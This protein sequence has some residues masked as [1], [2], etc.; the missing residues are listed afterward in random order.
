MSECAKLPGAVLLLSLAR[1]CAAQS[2]L[3]HV[4]PDPPQTQ[5]HDM[6]YSDMADM[7][8]MDDRAPFGLFSLDQLEWL[9]DERFA[10]QIDAWYGGDIDKLWL[11]AEAA[12]DSGETHDA[13]AELLW[14][15]VIGRWWNLQTGLRQDLGAH[16]RTWV[17]FGIQGL[18]PGFVHV[19]AT[20]YLGEGG[21]TA[22]RFVA[23]YDLLLTQ[24]WV[25]QPELELELL[26][27][28]DAMRGISAGLSDLG[29]GLRLRYEFRREFAPYA[30]I[31]WAARA[32]GEDADEL[33]LL[34]GL[35]L[36]F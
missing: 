13:S 29:L 4:P 32:D 7:M 1:V 18:A 15:H 20:A 26:G 33:R 36:W 6:P 10:G 16:S 31:T 2:E 23:E 35:R 28:D 9:D 8:G 3:E 11:K 34:A 24:R 14:D 12:R 19:E 22:A 30:G 25:L 21:H 17:A 27:S 5:V